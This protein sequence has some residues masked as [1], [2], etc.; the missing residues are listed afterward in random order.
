MVI[1]SQLCPGETSRVVIERELCARSHF[2]RLI[3]RQAA[4][5]TKLRR[6]LCQYAGEPGFSTG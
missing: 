3:L 4:D 1:K 5:L 6:T 2:V